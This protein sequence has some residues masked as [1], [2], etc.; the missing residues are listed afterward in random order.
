LKENVYRCGI[1][2][3]PR[4]RA[5]STEKLPLL[6]FNIKPYTMKEITIRL[7]NNIL[8][9]RESLPLL[10]E[11]D[12]SAKPNPAK[13]SKKEILGH[14]VDSAVNNLKR[15]TDAPISEAPYVV[16]SYAQD[17]L[18]KRNRYQE[19]PTEEIV[20]LWQS[21]NS[22]ICRV[23]EHLSLS[24]LST[25]VRLGKEEKTLS[26]LIE[27]YI[28]HMEHHFAQLFEGKETGAA[29]LKCHF[30]PD[31]G[32]QALATVAT[33]FARLLQYHD[34]EV[35]YYQPDK[36]DKQQPHDKDEL[37]IIASGSGGFLLEETRYEVRENDVLFV[38]AKKEHRF[39]EFTEDFATWVI[40]YGSKF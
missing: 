23:M 29:S 24:D 10:S 25:K 15:F 11:S 13:W 17:A 37:Y 9:L 35:E 39:V 7:K 32:R 3:I 14:L 1:M 20:L 28:L 4:R 34:L 18:V 12:L 33:E 22:Q 19:M 27:D 6:F 8:K 38:P 16:E 5:T 40:F 30:T 21:L 36:V 26:W 2:P 31:D